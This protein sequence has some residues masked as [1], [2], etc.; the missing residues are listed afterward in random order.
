MDA[1]M[2]FLQCAQQDGSQAVTQWVSMKPNT[3]TDSWLKV[4]YILHMDEIWGQV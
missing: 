4:F 3:D 1:I 2:Y